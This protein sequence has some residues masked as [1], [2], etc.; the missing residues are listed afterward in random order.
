MRYDLCA[1]S[2]VGKV[3]KNNEDNFFVNGFF[4]NNYSVDN[5]EYEIVSDELA[6][7]IFAV[8]DGMGG[9]QFGEEASGMAAE[10]LNKYYQAL[11]NEGI[12]F[13]GSL[14]VRKINNAVCKTARSF[15][16]KTGSTIVMCVINNSALSVINVGDSRAYLYR[17][18]NLKQLSV[19]HN[20]AAVFKQMNIDVPNSKNVLTQHLGIEESEFVLEPA[21]SKPVELESGDIILLCSDGLCGYVSDE[22][23]ER[24]NQSC[25][26]VK[27]KTNE[28]IEA[29]LNEGGNDNITV[30]LIEIK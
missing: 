13:N 12:E 30:I 21:I 16:A 29:A 14:A 6:F 24:I 28:L 4:R 11:K 7:E 22:Q 8:F 26:T 15:S 2:V 23:I 3:R 17:D 18:S 20:E 1:V 27:E 25:K 5:F 9:A 19:D 10:A